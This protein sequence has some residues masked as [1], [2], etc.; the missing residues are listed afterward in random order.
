MKVA[1]IVRAAGGVFTGVGMYAE[2]GKQELL[3]VAPTLGKDV[4]EGIPGLGT[5][6]SGVAV[7]WDIG[8]GA[9]SIYNCYNGVKE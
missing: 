9:V 3:H 2:T 1:G 5:I 4:A 7:L 8:S 6:V